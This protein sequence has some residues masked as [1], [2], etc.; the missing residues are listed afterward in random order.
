MDDEPGAAGTSD[1]DTTSLPDAQQ[2]RVAVEAEVKDLLNLG[3][4]HDELVEVVADRMFRLASE[5]MMRTFTHRLAEYLADLP[6]GERRARAIEILAQISAL[7]DE[8]TAGR[9][10]EQQ[11]TKSPGENG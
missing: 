10:G 3:L 6:E 7:G 4:T 5:M 1:G 8:P 11:G 9:T 2:I